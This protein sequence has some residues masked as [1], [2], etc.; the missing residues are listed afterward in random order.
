MFTV[1]NIILNAVFNTV[2]FH[3]TSI[4]RNSLGSKELHYSFELLYREENNHS[5][6]VL[7]RNRV[8]K[9]KLNTSGLSMV[10][11]CNWVE[12]N[13]DLFNINEEAPVLTESDKNVLKGTM[14]GAM[15]CH[16]SRTEEKCRNILN[17]TEQADEDFMEE[18]RNAYAE[19][20]CFLNDYYMYLKEAWE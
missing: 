12:L 9:T 13:I 18:V 2:H 4:I 1:N 3:V 16:L 7:C 10:Q 11:I 20:G 6:L 17:G 14:M 8:L 5:I 15:V 19:C